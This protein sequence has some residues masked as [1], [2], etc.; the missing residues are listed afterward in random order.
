MD[1][2]VVEVTRKVFEWRDVLSIEEAGI[3]TCNE[4]GEE[5]L[6]FLT[7]NYME[8]V[9]RGD[10]EKFRDNWFSYREWAKKEDL[11]IKQFN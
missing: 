9:I 5:K 10:Y 7:L 6:I 4:L 3:D 11:K 1:T 8:M 2:Q